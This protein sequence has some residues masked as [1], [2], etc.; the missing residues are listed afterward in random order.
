MSIKV[1]A[2]PTVQKRT[3]RAH[4]ALILLYN[5]L[6]ME[7]S[8]H[9][10]TISLIIPCYNEEDV[11]NICHERIKSVI[12]LLPHKFEI[13]YVDD[14][15]KDK[16]R[17]ILKAIQHKDP[18]VTLLYLSRNFGKEAAMTAGLDECTGDAAIILDADL[19]DPPELI[20]DLIKKW[21]DEQAD[22][23]YCQR[24]TREGEGP[25]KKSTAAAFYKIINLVSEIDIPVNT[26]DFRLMN[27]RAVNAVKSI[28]EHHRFM[29]GL[30]AWIGYKQVPLHYNRKERAAGT[31][32]WNYWRLW[33]FALEGV[34]GFSMTPLRIASL[35]GLVISVFSFLIGTIILIK[36]LIHGVDVPGYASVMVMLT[37]LSGI[38]LL[39]IGILGEYIGRIFGETKHRPLY[40]V[41][42]K[43]SRNV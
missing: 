33:N 4:S 14:G 10:L 42:E 1:L 36:T 12:N 6:L 28:R 9:H 16:T 24:L 15:S 17:D 19:Q 29:K 5:L 18:L 21:K 23:V 35:C 38:Q 40:F 7:N 34:T 25:L 41:Q 32:K 27:R 31:T 37:F 30:F 43:I 22:V 13:I 3:N 20:P 26:G 11:I 8:D 2:K 39:T